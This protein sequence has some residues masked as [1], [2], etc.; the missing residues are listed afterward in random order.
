MTVLPLV[1]ERAIHPTERL[2]GENNLVIPPV[3]VEFVPL[4]QDVWGCADNFGPLPGGKPVRENLCFRFGR[5][6]PELSTAFVILLRVFKAN[7]ERETYALR[8]CSVGDVSPTVRYSTMAR[9]HM[10]ELFSPGRR[11][12]CSPFGRVAT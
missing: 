3:F 6:R 4:D 5:V 11:V 12:L 10:Q 2:L 8:L 1:S 9:G 7:I